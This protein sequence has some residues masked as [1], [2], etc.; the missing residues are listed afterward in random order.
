MHERA[1][2][3]SVRLLGRIMRVRLLAVLAVVALA[4]CGGFIQGSDSET[5]TL[6]PAPVPS[7][8]ATPVESPAVGDGRV[9]V[10]TGMAAGGLTDSTALARQHVAAINGT[11]YVW[12][13]RYVETLRTDNVSA[14]RQTTQRV[15]LE[16][17]TTHRHVTSSTETGDRSLGT[18]PYDHLEEGRVE[19]RDGYETYANG[20]V[21]Y[22]SWFDFRGEDRIFERRDAVT[23][24]TAFDTLAR[25]PIERYIDPEASTVMILDGRGNWYEVTSSAPSVS[26]QPTVENYSARAVI[27]S[28]GFVRSLTVSYE[29]QISGRTVDVRYSFRYADVGTATVEPPDWLAEAKSKFEDSPS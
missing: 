17:A 4:G 22:V 7:P 21:E 18:A 5:P 29:R 3:F 23:D 13:E 20:D 9:G 16:N 14:Q 1:T 12:T 19:Y 24:R 28:D 8:T 27:R 26:L 10:A 15:T 25:G 6:T 2:F 11:S